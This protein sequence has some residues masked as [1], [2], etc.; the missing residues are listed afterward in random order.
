MGF[1]MRIIIRLK[2]G[3]RKVK[4]PE[5]A[6][7]FGPR[8]NRKSVRRNFKREFLKNS[9]INPFFGIGGRIFWAFENMPPENCL[10]FALR[11]TILQNS[12]GGKI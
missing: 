3:S 12:L 8:E 4:F 7:R 2:K 5:A 11:F 9:D 1:P 6:R 10:A